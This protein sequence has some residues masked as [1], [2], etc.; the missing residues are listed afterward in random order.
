MLAS[1]LQALAPISPRAPVR[2]GP[3]PPRAAPRAAKASGGRRRR[4]QAGPRRGPSADEGCA[5]AGAANRRRAQGL[6]IS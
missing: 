1:V 2:P 4:R 3:H 5:D 6:F